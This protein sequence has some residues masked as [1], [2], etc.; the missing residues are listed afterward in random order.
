MSRACSHTWPTGKIRADQLD[1][2]VKV[3]LLLGTYLHE[4]HQGRL[5]GKAQ[6]LRRKVRQDYENALATCDLPVMPTH[7]R[8]AQP[9]LKANASKGGTAGESKIQAR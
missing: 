3:D 1:L 9:Y 8:K 4:N 2:G 6:N 7:P 5:Y